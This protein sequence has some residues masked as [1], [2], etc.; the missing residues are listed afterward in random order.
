MEV[1]ATVNRRARLTERL[2]TAVARAEMSGR[3]VLFTLAVPAG[4]ADPLAVA[5][6][7]GAPFA[8]WEQPARRMAC[9]AMGSAQTLLT[10]GD[11]RFAAM[12]E[13]LADLRSR[14]MHQAWDGA[15]R[16]PLLIGGF[17][18]DDSSGWPGF[19][20]GRL[21][22]PELALIRRPAGA[23]WTAAAAVGAADDPRRLADRLI[24]RI[25]AAAGGAAE[26]IRPG[27]GD[28]RAAQDADLGD[29]AFVETAQAAIKE[30]AA[31]G[32]SKVV[33]ARRWT[34]GRRPDPGPF[35]AALREHF[36]ECA[37]FAFAPASASAEPGGIFCGATPELL[38]RVEGA[39]VSTVAMAGTAPRGRDAA[40]DRAIAER[41]R[42]D[43]KQMEEHDFVLSE[44]RRRLR[45]GGF[46]LRPPAPTGV[47]RLPGLQH[48]ATPVSATA[49]VR[50]NVLDVAGALHP[51]PAVAG[52]PTGA[53]RDWIRA[54]EGFD[55]GWFAGPVGFCDLA[56][57][58]EFHV[59]LRSALLGREGSALFA[60]AGV[61]AASDPVRELEE[62]ELKLRSLLPWLLGS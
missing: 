10:A 30:I 5:V 11:D 15:D 22:L 25:E 13:A 12:S 32:L 33:P 44:I 31:G 23:S 8:F 42:S 52:V 35:L 1:T 28:R 20:A 54:H 60:G 53:A 58:G 62:T 17:S 55:R 18:W 34:V 9:A 7:S 56:G 45:R 6:G 14:T 39:S 46:A 26:P 2:A 47:M 48:L 24:G 38:A 4:E 16:T 40:A 29:P 49:P 41:L 36:T 50:C 51:T 43:P 59:A 37:I 3:P 61:V 27:P 57:G 19:P 21:V